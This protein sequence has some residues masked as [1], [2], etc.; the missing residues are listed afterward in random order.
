MPSQKNKTYFLFS[1]LIILGYLWIGISMNVGVDSKIIVCPI[2]AVTG[3]PC[4]SCG[5]TRSVLYL[6]EG[7]YWAAINSNP[8]GILI[9]LILT[10]TPSWLI[11]DLV[12]NRDSLWRFYRKVET[13][14]R[15]R[16]IAI[17][18]IIMVL[19]NWIWNIS[20]GL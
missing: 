6:L 7:N 3:F 14:V 20:K 16:N 4:P 18:L 11:Y 19:T 2:K 17:I 1:V 9:L 12:N 13:N 15:K 5:S 8:F 10:I